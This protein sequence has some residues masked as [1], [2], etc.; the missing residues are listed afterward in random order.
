M[1][2]GKLKFDGHK[3]VAQSLKGVMKA[4]PQTE[5]TRTKRLGVIQTLSTFSCHCDCDGSAELSLHV[6]FL[7]TFPLFPLQNIHL[8]LS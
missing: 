3:E 5:Q 1:K 6:V 7:T 2:S 4:S 8:C